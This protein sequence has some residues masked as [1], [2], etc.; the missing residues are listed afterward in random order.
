MG[1]ETLLKMALA[2]GDFE[3]ALGQFNLQEGS[4]ASKVI[5]DS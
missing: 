2:A 3:T 4:L 5:V 1:P